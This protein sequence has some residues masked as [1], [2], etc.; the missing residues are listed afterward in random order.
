MAMLSRHPTWGSTGNRSTS[1][2]VTASIRHMASRLI[3][4]DAPESLQRQR[5]ARVRPGLPWAGSR[6]DEAGGDHRRCE[7]T[8]PAAH[9][10]ILRPEVRRGPP[11]TPSWL[12][13]P[14]SGVSPIDR[15][16]S[17]GTE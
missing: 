4:G 12:A 9:R 10:Y 16:L 14:A 7:N 11:K 15:I 2:S 13:R 8:G 5:R 6:R 17:T 1:V 3:D